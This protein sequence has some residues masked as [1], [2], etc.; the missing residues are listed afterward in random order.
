ME[1]QGVTVLEAL[2]HVRERLHLVKLSSDM[3]QALAAYRV[4]AIEQ[5]PPALQSGRSR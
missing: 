2:L 1:M 3:Q 4:R 5:Q